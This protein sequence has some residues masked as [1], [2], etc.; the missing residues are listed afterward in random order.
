MSNKIKTRGT[1]PY[2]QKIVLNS[3]NNRKVRRKP[4]KLCPDCKETSDCVKIFSSKV[5]KI[6]ETVNNFYT[7]LPKK[8]IRQISTFNAKFT[9]NNV[10][11]EVDYDLSK[12]TLENLQKLVIF[13]T[14]NCD[15]NN[16]NNKYPSSIHSKSSIPSASSTSSND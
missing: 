15:N 2:V 9:L 5:N 11:C 1:P 4:P 6:E 7:N 8:S 16:E 12:F 13:T 3:N 10:P 14:Q